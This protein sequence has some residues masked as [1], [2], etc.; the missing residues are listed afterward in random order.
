MNSVY[1]ETN[2]LFLSE[3]YALYIGENSEN[4]PQF[5]ISK[6]KEADIQGKTSTTSMCLTKK[7]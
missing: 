7:N 4:I 2:K 6:K 3:I 1:L 5:F